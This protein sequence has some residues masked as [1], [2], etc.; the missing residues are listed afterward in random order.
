M[1]KDIKTTATVT[2]NGGK[3]DIRGVVD[4]NGTRPAIDGGRSHR[5]FL[6]SAGTLSLT[7]ISITNG[8]VRTISPSL[9]QNQTK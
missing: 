2:V 1:A 9:F 6:V 3:L 8:H 5:L 4:S 7:N